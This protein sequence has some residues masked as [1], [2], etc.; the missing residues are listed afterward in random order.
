MDEALDG[1]DCWQCTELCISSASVM[2]MHN[3]TSPSL[4]LF[5]SFSPLLL[6]SYE[7]DIIMSGYSTHPHEACDDEDPQAGEQAVRSEQTGYCKSEGVPP[8]EQ[9]W[10][11]R[12]IVQPLVTGAVNAPNSQFAEVSLGLEGV[13]CQSTKHS[14]G[15]AQGLQHSG[16]FIEGHCGE[17][18]AVRTV[19]QQAQTM[20]TN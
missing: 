12:N 10:L 9:H 8:I 14:T 2:K 11:K 3:F 19:C 6:L 20:E 7:T 17:E 1:S 16:V 18:T 5:Q 15:Q 4:S 13:G